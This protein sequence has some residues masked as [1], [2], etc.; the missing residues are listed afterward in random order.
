VVNEFS[1]DFSG[2]P[3]ASAIDY[4]SGYYQMPLDPCS[5][6]L[7]AFWT[8]IGLLRMVCLP[9]GW[10][11]SV[12]AFQRALAKVH[13]RQL[14]RNLKLFIDDVGL[15]GPKHRYNDEE[16]EPGIKRSVWKHAQEFR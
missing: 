10:T 8:E 7:A 1:E 4:Y 16:M 3:I 12:A 13:W 15:K 11:G 9:Q 5:R 6:D 14:P 2:Y